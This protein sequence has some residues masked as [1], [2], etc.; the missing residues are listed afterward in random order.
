MD[1]EQSDTENQFIPSNLLLNKS[2]KDNNND[3]QSYRQYFDNQI[4]GFRPST[5]SDDWSENRSNSFRVLHIKSDEV[6]DFEIPF[7]SILDDRDNN[8]KIEGR[9]DDSF[10][11][12]SPGE[13]DPSYSHYDYKDVI[14]QPQTELLW[15]G[16]HWQIEKLLMDIAF[17]EDVCVNNEEINQQIVRTIL[18]NNGQDGSVR[19]YACCQS[20]R[21]TDIQYNYPDQRIDEHSSVAFS[22]KKVAKLFYVSIIISNF[23]VTLDV[24][25]NPKRFCFDYLKKVLSLGGTFQI[26]R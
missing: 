3:V 2:D 6:K 11:H 1:L 14:I 16:P 13:S 9:D 4:I 10:E 26:D 5:N 20:K 12:S 19:E 22:F 18:L 21:I 17:A 15:S 7:D 24:P 23:T 8:I 25:I